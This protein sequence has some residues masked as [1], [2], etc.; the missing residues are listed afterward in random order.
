MGLAVVVW[1]LRGRHATAL[2]GAYIVFLSGYIGLAVGFFPN[3]V[4]YD[5]DFRA[6]A[7]AD[8]ALAIML[9]GV[10]ILLPVI[11]GYTV[12]VYWLFRGKVGANASYH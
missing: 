1:G 11:L 12:W 6:A 5:M 9:V 3:I 2:V 10:G 7:N 8:N 4:P